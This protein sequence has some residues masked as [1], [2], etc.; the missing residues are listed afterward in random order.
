MTGQE[1][2][3]A[4]TLVL[5]PLSSQQKSVICK[6]A[7]FLVSEA[8]KSKV[9]PFVFTSLIYYE[10]AFRPR[11]V[12]YAGAC[13]LTQVLPRYSR[14]TC[15]QLKN[16]R[17]SIKEGL[18][19]LRVW[20]QRAKGNQRLALC[21]YNAGNKCFTSKSFKRKIQKRYSDKIIITANRLYSEVTNDNPD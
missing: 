19:H 4:V 12:S 2:C 1:L 11:V 10:S 6:N 13:G 9:D 8:T 3:M 21:G 18:R 7:D 14:Y 5:A 15:E 17:T 20:L 16:P